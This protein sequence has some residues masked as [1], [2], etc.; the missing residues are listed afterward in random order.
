MET[1]IWHIISESVIYST[2]VRVW[3]C[4]LVLKAEKKA[5]C[6]LQRLLVSWPI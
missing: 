3:M 2:F 6:P 4:K 5:R 1:Y